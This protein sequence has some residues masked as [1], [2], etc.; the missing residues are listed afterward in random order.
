VQAIQAMPASLCLLGCKLVPWLSTCWSG[1]W[2]FLADAAAPFVH[3]K[4]V[5]SCSCCCCS[6][7]GVLRGLSKE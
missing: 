1:E 7:K 4:C 5:A 6:H 3:T 2:P